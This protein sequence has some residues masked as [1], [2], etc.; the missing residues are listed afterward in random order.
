[1]N[2]FNIFTCRRLISERSC[3]WTYLLSL[4]SWLYQFNTITSRSII[5]G[6]VI[7]AFPCPCFF[8]A[9]SEHMPRDMNPFD[10]CQTSFDICQTHFYTY[11]Y[12]TDAQHSDSIR[13]LSLAQEVWSQQLL[14]KKMYVYVYESLTKKTPKNWYFYIY[15][16]ISLNRW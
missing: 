8:F 10:S 15:Y 7:L 4:C 3:S 13:F 14:Y 16:L 9:W 5:S 2:K 6:H 1:M 11:N 12:T